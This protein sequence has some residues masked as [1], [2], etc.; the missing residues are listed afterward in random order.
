MSSLESPIEEL[1]V[2]ASH[3]L[4][5][6]IR[7]MDRGERGIVLVVDD[8]RRLRAAVV[9]GDLRRAFMAG[10]SLDDPMERLLAF[11]AQRGEGSPV[12]APRESPPAHLIR[13]MRE[14]YVR[15]IPLVDSQ[16]RVVDLV[17]QRDLLPSQDQDLCLEAVIMAGGYGTRLRPL[18]QDTPKPLL[19]VG[20][21]PLMGRII[22]QLR[23]AGIK[24]VNVSTHYLADKISDH[25]GD[26]SQV[27]VEISYLN[28]KTPLGTAG[29]LG[30]MPP[31]DQTLLVIN[32]DI[33]TQMDFAAMRDFHRQQ[34]ADLTVG[35]R[36]Y[37]MKVPFGVVETKGGLVTRL[38]EKPVLDFFVNAGVYLVEPRAHAQIPS[39]GRFD[40]TDLIQK[41]LEQ[42]AAVASFPIIEYWLD[43]GSPSDYE[44]AQEDVKN[45][46]LD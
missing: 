18:T 39:G 15:Q 44:R 32:G 28:E 22:E 35:V 41:L 20:E 43:I 31:P 1:F 25:F 9:D 42:G 37:E 46:R 21:Q 12:S 45:H 24:R 2:S 40:M 30:L 26:G 13:L 3:T 5:Q 6:A 17:T 29:A 23:Q 19:P 27:G 10:L 11:K 34:K 8:Q 14:H 36:K 33:L 16:G 7:H 4:R 38:Q